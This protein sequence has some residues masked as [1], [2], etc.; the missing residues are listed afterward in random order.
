METTMEMM[1]LQRDAVLEFES[2][3]G[4]LHAWWV[5]ACDQVRVA[6]QRWCG[7]EAATRDDCYA[8]LIAMMDQEATAA[9]V[10]GRTMTVL[11][12]QDATSPTVLDTVA[13]GAR[14][15]S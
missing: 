8:V 6:Y 2:D 5:A 7:A 11:A 10:Y 13:L 3:P 4:V 14:H 12:A 15:A 9:T 1:G